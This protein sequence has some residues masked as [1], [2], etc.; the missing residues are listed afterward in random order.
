METNLSHGVLDGEVVRT[1]KGRC[2][3]FPVWDQHKLRPALGFYLFRYNVQ[4][5]ILYILRVWKDAEKVPPLF[6]V[7]CCQLNRLCC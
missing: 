2:I 6:Q 4:A 3:A 1:S 7:C 5:R